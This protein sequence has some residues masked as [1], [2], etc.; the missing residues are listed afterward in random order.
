MIAAAL[1]NK[2]VWALL[3]IGALAS[4]GAWEHHEVAR[5][6]AEYDQFKGGVTALGEQAKAAAA[7]KEKAD[8]LKKDQADHENQTTI[9]T[10]TTERDSLRQQRASSRIVPTAPAGASQPQTACFDRAG[11]E[12][13][14][15]RFDAGASGL[16]GEGAE[17][18]ADLD[19]DRRWAQS[20]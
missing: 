4:Y 9:A 5:I 12:S 15:Q 18:I 16:V 14:L 7:A 13:A 11:L 10:L 8:Q 6:T 2:W 1:M 20:P 19:I 17:A 3:I